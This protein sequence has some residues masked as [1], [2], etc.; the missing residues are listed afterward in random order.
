MARRRGSAR[1]A[2]R[3][4][5]LLR[6]ASQAPARDLLADPIMRH[7]AELE[8]ESTHQ[9]SRGILFRRRVRHHL[10]N[11]VVREGDLD[12]LAAHGRTVAALLVAWEGEANDLD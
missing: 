8:A 2:I 12:E 1:S 4:C 10:A 7:R 6:R 3:T 11:L 9:P 5:A